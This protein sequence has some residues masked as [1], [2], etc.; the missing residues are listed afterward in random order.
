M[1]TFVTRGGGGARAHLIN[2]NRALAG[3]VV[4]G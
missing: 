3:K 4:L 1:T 2:R